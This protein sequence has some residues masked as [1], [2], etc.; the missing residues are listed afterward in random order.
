MLDLK[1]QSTFQK[2]GKFSLFRKLQ[3]H[4]V[5]L[6]TVGGTRAGERQ[7]EKDTGAGCRGLSQREHS[8]T[9]AE[10]PPRPTIE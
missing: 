6:R 1:E 7:R 3:S 8:Q 9:S 4:M 2:C 10:A 5:T